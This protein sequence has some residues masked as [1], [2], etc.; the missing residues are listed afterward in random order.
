MNR[1]PG[2]LFLRNLVERR[3]LVAQ[4]VRR[5][6]QQRYVGSAAGWVWGMIHPL[7]MLLSWVFVFQIC[8]K[9]QLP[10]HEVTQNYTLF[11][12]CR[13]LPWMLFQ[14][15]VNRSSTALVDQA[16]LITKTVFPS[17]VVPISIF[18][19]SLLNH[20]LAL[21]IVMAVVGFTQDHFSLMVLLLPAY[22]LL[23]GMLAIGIGWIAASMHVYLRDTAQMLSVVLTLWFWLTP[24][25]IDEDKY[26]PQMR[27]LLWFNPLAYLVRAYRDRL[28]TS[29]APNLEDLG[30]LTVWSLAAFV[31]G[32]LFFRQ[33]KRGFADVL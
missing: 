14:E 18:V 17:E 33:L 15:T 6:F 13:F 12:I 3:A 7:A 2:T 1:I 27:W 26:P 24:I 11:L 10:H 8:M 20:L 9:V 30:A 22:M 25:F 5:D 29:R 31:A 21:V 32:G 23:L 4:L 16:N 28:L 19:S